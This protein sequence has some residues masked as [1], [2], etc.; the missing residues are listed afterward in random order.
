MKTSNTAKLLIL[1]LALLFTQLLKAQISISGSLLDEGTKEPIA[2]ATISLHNEGDSSLIAGAFTQDNG[3]FTVAT[4]Q[5]GKLLL[6]AAYLGYQSRWRSIY[7]GE[8][9]DIL[10][11]GKLLLNPTA[12]TLVA[13]TVSG[14]RATVSGALDKKSFDLSDQN[15]QT[16]GSVLDA[17]KALP[18]VSTTQDGNLLLR[19]SDRVAVLID[20]KQSAITGYGNQRGLDNIPAANIARIE[21]INN[22]SAKYDATGM[23]GIINIIYKENKESGFNG[24]VGLNYAL[25]EITN[26]R[27][28][29]PTELGRYNLNSRVIPNLSLNY[30]NSKFNSWFQG[31]MLFQQRLPNNEFTTRNYTDGRSTIS[32]VPENRKQTHYILKSGIDYAAN[33]HDTYSLSAIYDY[34]IHTD[35]AQ[36][37]YIDLATNQRYRYWNWR[38]RESTGLFNVKADYRHN[39]GQPGHQL[40]LAAQYTR[41]S[42]DEAYFLNDSTALRR[43]NDTTHLIAIERTLAFNLD[44]VR[45]LGSGRIEAGAKAQGRN[46]PITYN[47]GRGERS[48]IYP[49]LGD[50]SQWTEDLY[51][52]YLNYVFERPGFDVEFGLSAE[53]IGVTYDLAE[54]NIYYAENDAYNYFRLYPNFRFTYKA[55]DRNSVSLFFNRRVDRPGEPELRA[56]PKYDDPELLKVG[57]PYLRPQFTQTV[58]LAYR[59]NWESG[60]VFEHFTTGTSTMLF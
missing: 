11:V 27:T 31:E 37:P 9:N 59:R 16:A 52:A 53:Q 33:E 22:P 38:E 46:I 30:R 3:D 42:E 10:S 25:G 60:S 51:A 39:F 49:G 56:F 5:R 17:M 18:G 20:G 32:Q 14:E 44:Y 41:A 35:T 58:E 28:D 26:R 12:T 57:N 36:F 54:E 1:T 50:N 23:A 13:V 2:Y 19:G 55:S 47:I 8:K 40:N 15:A 29:L 34:E 6:Q 45:P 7:V 21:I 24:E 43:A 4:S 48:I